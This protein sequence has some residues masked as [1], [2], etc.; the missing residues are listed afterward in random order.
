MFAYND[1]RFAI[2]R[3]DSGEQKTFAG[4]QG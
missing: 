2:K 1:W 3:F 4:R